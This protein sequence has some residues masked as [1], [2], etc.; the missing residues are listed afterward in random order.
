MFF[1][2]KI[3]LSVK[4]CK[5]KTSLTGGFN[6]RT[7]GDVRSSQ[8]PARTTLGVS[9]VPSLRDLQSVLTLCCRRFASTVNEVLSLRDMIL[10]ENG[11]LCEKQ[12]AVRYAIF[13]LH[14]VS[15]TGHPTRLRNFFY[16]HFVP[17]GTERDIPLP[18]Q[19]I[20]KHI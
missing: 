4:S 8:S 20:Y 14:I 18:N 11:F 5:D 19:L 2:P 1:K 6:L 16:Q 13:Y 17:N 10:V 9:E 12:R 15:L 7:R 3:S